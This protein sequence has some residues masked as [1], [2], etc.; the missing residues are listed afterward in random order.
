VIGTDFGPGTLT[1][2]GYPRLLKLWKRGTPL[3]KAATLF[4]VEATDVAATPIT[5]SDL[6]R[7]I[8][9]V[10][11]T[12][13]FFKTE[14]HLLS[15]GRLRR[16]PLPIDAILLGPC[17]GRLFA[18]LRGA[19]K[20]AERAFAAGSLVALPIDSL[21]AARAE[22]VLEPTEKTS[23][24]AMAFTRR[25]AYASLLDDVAGAIV[26]VR[27]GDD[28]RWTAI[29][30]PY[31]ENGAT[32]L[33][34]WSRFDDELI[35]M[36][37]SPIV[38]SS[39]YVSARPGAEPKLLKRAP[40]RFD[41]KGLTVERFFATSRDG[42]RIPYFVSRPQRLA[43]DGSAPTLLY[44]YGGFELPTIPNYLGDTGKWWLEKGGVWV[45]ANIRGGGEYGPRWH[46]SVLK[47]NREKVFEDFVAVAEDLIARKITSPQKL[48]I[49]GRSNG[50]LLVGAAFTRRPE[51][52]AA[53]SCGSP[54]LDM[55]RYHKLLAGASWIGEY[56]DP[57]DPALRDVIRG[58]SPYQNLS[59]DKKYPEVFFYTSTKDDRVHPGHAR[60]MAARMEE[61]KHPFVYYENIEGGHS[62]AANLEQ[63]VRR[64]AL[65]AVYF[66]QKLMDAK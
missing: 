19:W 18:K 33:V 56:G 51:L 25:A 39:L 37:S 14:Y 35:V 4:E 2:S 23:I 50:G 27:R 17:Q 58:Y 54:L 30:Q 55:L 28:G 66:Y 10:S 15:E 34:T 21:D 43:L 31:P 1:T 62:A 29:R 44:G 8:T 53:V 61:M 5:Y 12:P 38:P 65:Q 49:M 40:E 60:K 36:H 32:E 26:E 20:P 3:E 59:P 13:A 48:G 64:A 7:E 47:E 63:S 24:Q 45:S 6:D 57:E 11:R 16:I 22:S 52:F 41:A 42:S 46:E 9:V